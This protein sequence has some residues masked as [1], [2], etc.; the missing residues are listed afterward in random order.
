MRVIRSPRCM[1]AYAAGL[2][3][4]APP[5]QPQRAVGAQSARDVASQVGPE[6]ADRTARA[7]APVG[8]FVERA[9]LVHDA[10]DDL[11][12]PHRL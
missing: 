1:P 10:A 2:A 8:R 4:Q 11:L 6:V 3:R 9:L 5:S 12:Q 7:A